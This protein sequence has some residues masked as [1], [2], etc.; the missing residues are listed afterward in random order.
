MAKVLVIDD[1]GQVRRIVC[2]MLRAGG[3]EA[4]ETGEGGV[5]L[6]LIERDAPDLVVTDL[7]MPGQDGIETIARIREI[8]GLPIIAM[9]G[10]RQD[11]DFA[12]LV[13][14][15]MMGADLT[16]KKPFT[17]DALLAAVNDL[18]QGDRGSPPP[19]D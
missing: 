18:L 2:R 17:M 4:I 11:G 5:G 14:A 15:Q 3:H 12:P 16:I 9:S 8:S 10:Q 1:D 19:Q 6:T 7:I 13:D